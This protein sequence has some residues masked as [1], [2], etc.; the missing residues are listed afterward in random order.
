M[1]CEDQPLRVIS[2]VW[3]DHHLNAS[4]GLVAVG[5][6]AFFQSDT[7]GDQERRVDLAFDDHPHQRLK[8]TLY[9]LLP[10]LQR[11]SLANK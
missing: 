6:G 1:D 11:Q 7:V 3:P 8:I 9:V 2:A 5:F 10:C 4:V